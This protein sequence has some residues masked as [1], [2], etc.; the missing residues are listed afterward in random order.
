MVCFSEKKNDIYIYLLIF[1]NQLIIKISIVFLQGSIFV[2]GPIKNV[3]FFYI[4]KECGI[5]LHFFSSFIRV[6]K[7]S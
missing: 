4:Y 6:K 3:V 5:N 7:I 1:L 2:M